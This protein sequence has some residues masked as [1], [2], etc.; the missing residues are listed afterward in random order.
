MLRRHPLLFTV[1]L[2]EGYVV[3]AAELLA[4]RL[5]IPF[6][7]SGVEVVAIVISGVLL[8][9]AAGYHAG[10]GRLQRMIPPRS[11]RK[12]LIRNLLGAMLALSFGLSFLF[13]GAWFEWL[14][15]IGITHPLVQATCYVA[16]FLVYPVYLLAQTVPLVS[17]YFSHQRLSS[18]TGRMLFFSTIGSFLG[19][20]LSTLLLMNWLGVHLTAWLTIALLA[21]AVLLLLRRVL[22]YE[23]LLALC[24]VALMW[25]MNK[26]S[27]LASIGVV[28]SN[29]YNTASIRENKHDN[30]KE[31]LLNFSL[32]SKYAADPENRYA[33]IRALEDIIIRPLLQ[34]D[35]PVMDILV[36]G[37]GGFTLGWD[38]RKNNYTFVDI[39]KDLQAI[40]EAHLLPEKL[41]PNKRFIADSARR[42]LAQRKGDKRYDVIVVDVF[43]NRDS[44]PLEV[45][46]VEFWQDVEASLKPMGVVAA[47]VIMSPSFRN[48]F[49][50]RI[51]NTFSA[52][53]PHHVRQVPYVFSIWSMSENDNVLLIHRNRGTSDAATYSDDRTSHSI[54]RFRER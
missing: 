29:A 42:F 33:Y 35:A 16:V 6:V 52:V 31:L 18:A 40:S 26:P 41:P 19:S 5:L 7:G 38:D 30:S 36:I 34:D 17:H 27:S 25:A 53:F 54:D 50:A 51:V 10:G 22:S 24:C 39:D 15:R 45:T 12:L 32:S 23:A 44:V 2:I 14:S 49:S 37:A 1:I 47:N 8:P 20:V 48:R 4:M 28:A 9:L 3:L 21:M 13:I 11:V 46:T 43:S